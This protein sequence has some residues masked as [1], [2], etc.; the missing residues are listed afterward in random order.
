[1][2]VVLL[3][4]RGGPVAV[5]DRGGLRTPPATLVEPA[6]PGRDEAGGPRRREVHQWAGPWLLDERWWSPAA[7]RGAW[8]QVVLD[9]GC[10]ALLASTGTETTGWRLEALYD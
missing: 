5:D 7:R 10:A 9:D 3:D 4:P 2:D 6:V 8:L 1:V